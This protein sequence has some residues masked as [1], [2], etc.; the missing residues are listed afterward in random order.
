M[1]PDID[2]VEDL[3]AVVLDG[4][5]AADDAAPVGTVPISVARR[6]GVL[7]VEP[8]P[9]GGGLLWAEPGQLPGVE[10]REPAPHGETVGHGGGSHL[11]EDEPV[12]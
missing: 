3:E 5:D 4:L 8:R 1:W 7:P 9:V 11:E 6:T 2:D 10:V 12:D